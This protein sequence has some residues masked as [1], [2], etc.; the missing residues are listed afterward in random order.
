ML[1]PPRNTKTQGLAMV[2]AFFAVASA[3]ALFNLF[4]HYEPRAK[5][6]SF[7]SRRWIDNSLK[8][9]PY[10][11][12]EFM[13]DD[14]IARYK[15]VGLSRRRVHELLGCVELTKEKLEQIQLSSGNCTSSTHDF[16][17][18]EFDSFWT[19][20]LLEQKVSRFRRFTKNYDIPNQFGEPT[21]TPGEWYY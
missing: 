8:G 15:L 11:A 17:E 21:I 2:A 13:L 10:Y 16:L 14:F 9:G 3:M 4:P 5:R 12:N 20:N 7:D 18:I 6:P 1:E 19:S